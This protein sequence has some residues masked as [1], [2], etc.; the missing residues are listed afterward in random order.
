[1]CI[2]ELIE[3][4]QMSSPAKNTAQTTSMTDAVVEGRD[5]TWST[6]LDPALSEQKW[7]QFTKDDSPTRNS[8]PNPVGASGS[9]LLGGGSST[10]GANNLTTSSPKPVDGNASPIPQG[11]GLTA[12]QTIFAPAPPPGPAVSTQLQSGP[13][14]T[15]TI[16]P[17]PT[18]QEP[19]I[20]YPVGTGA[21]GAPLFMALTPSQ[22]AA[23]GG[24]PQNLLHGA[25][26]PQAVDGHS[27]P[28]PAPLNHQPQPQQQSMQPSFVYPV[29][30]LVPVG[31][32]GGVQL[33][34]PPGMNVP[35]PVP[36][37]T[38]QVKAAVG[39]PTTPKYQSPM[40]AG[41]PGRPMGPLLT[42]SGKMQM[43]KTPSMTTPVLL[44]MPGVAAPV[45]HQAQTPPHS[46]PFSANRT[47]GGDVVGEQMVWAAH[48]HLF[49]E[50]APTLG[51]VRSLAGSSQSNNVTPLAASARAGPAGTPQAVQKA[52]GSGNPSPTAG[53]RKPTKQ[54]M[55]LQQ[56]QAS[57]PSTTLPAP[58]KRERKELAAVD[59]DLTSGT[60]SG[61]ALTPSASATAEGG[62]KW[63]QRAEL[64]ERLVGKLDAQTPNGPGPLSAS[65]TPVAAWKAKP[66][67]SYL[68]TG[69]CKYGDKCVF[70]HEKEASKEEP[71]SV[72][73]PSS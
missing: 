45:M 58:D 57:H 36:L 23:V 38:M 18:T 73:T 37:A 59:A 64:E 14:Q 4:H 9:G 16:Q 50:Q 68:Q 69:T 29:S 17:Q 42:P 70:S 32:P 61:V 54:E 15:I 40:P 52:S 10:I 12:T 63:S 20:L 51:E 43:A 13:S 31:A 5:L 71:K 47:H 19:T 7:T 46:G 62:S 56:L 39:V 6:D 30:N 48:E 1:M 33:I 35:I 24:N 11:G 65:S 67:K 53:S 72:V 44:P 22:L 28:Q 55:L 2:R 3:T 8:N 41:V 49:H 27:A 21:N 66:C 25:T 26:L 34:C 60:G